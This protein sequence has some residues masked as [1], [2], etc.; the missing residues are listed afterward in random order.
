MDSNFKEPFNVL[1][2]LGIVAVLLV[3]TL[4]A[5]LTWIGILSI[6]GIS[7]GGKRGTDTDTFCYVG[8]WLA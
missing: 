1:Y 4:P 5:T 8:I 7:F 6:N 3:P 2:F